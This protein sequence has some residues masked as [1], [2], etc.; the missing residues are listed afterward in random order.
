MLKASRARSAF[1]RPQKRVQPL[2]DQPP[3]FRQESLVALHGEQIGVSGDALALEGLLTI[4][5]SHLWEVEG[6][7][8]GTDLAVGLAADEGEVGDVIGLPGGG[9]ALE[10]SLGEDVVELQLVGIAHMA[11]GDDEVGMPIAGGGGL[12][13]QEHRLEQGAAL[14]STFQLLRGDIQPT[15]LRPQPIQQFLE[16]PAIAEDLEVL[17]EEGFARTSAVAA[18]GIGEQHPAA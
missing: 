11:E 14:I 3:P 2:S 4:G 6:R 17:I 12:K 7:L 5:L 13:G 18:L 8:L 9:S 10:N 16:A 1:A 15:H